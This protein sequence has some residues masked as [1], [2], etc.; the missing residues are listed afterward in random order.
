M[1][2]RTRTRRWLTPLLAAAI[3]T[4]ACGGDDGDGAEV[5]SAGSGASAAGTSTPEAIENPEQQLLEF[6]GCMRENGIDMPDPIGEEGLMDAMQSVMGDYGQDTIREALDACR[7]LLPAQ[8]RERAEMGEEEQL[9]L[10]ECL[11]DQ[12]LDVPDDLFDG[13]GLPEG[14][15]RQDLVGA[16]DECRELEP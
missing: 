10:A 8:I 16:M 6:A 3:L 1:P 11:R 13:G 2:N 5:A 15:S 14:I 4:G 7:E 9:E 12:G